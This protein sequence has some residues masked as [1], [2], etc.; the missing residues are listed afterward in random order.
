MAIPAADAGVGMLR[1]PSGNHAAGL[2][3]LVFRGD[4]FIA[5]TRRVGPG[6]GGVRL[7]D[8]VEACSTYY[9]WER[10]RAVPL[11]PQARG[12]EPSPPPALVSWAASFEDGGVAG[13]SSSPSTSKSENSA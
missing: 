6:S 8:A 2:L 3:A 12:P 9:R 7:S 11:R 1:R 4:R 10:D 5:A 13:L